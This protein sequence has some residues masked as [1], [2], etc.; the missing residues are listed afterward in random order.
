M[1]F[2]YNEV[3]TKVLLNFFLDSKVRTKVLV[4]FLEITGG[5]QKCTRI[6]PATVCKCD[7]ARNYNGLNAIAS[8]YVHLSNE[9]QWFELPPKVCKCDLARNY[10]G[11]SAIASIYVHLSQEIQWFELP[12]KVCKCDLARN[13]NGLSAI[14]VFPG[15]S[16]NRSKRLRACRRPKVP[17][18]D[19]Y[20]TENHH[21]FVACPKQRISA[22]QIGGI[23]DLSE[24]RSHRSRLA[25][26]RKCFEIIIPKK[27]IIIDLEPAWTREFRLLRPVG[28]W[29]CLILLI[30][31]L[32]K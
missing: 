23:L 12:P 27:E 4:G 8:I 28:F 31:T 18:N 9:L 6:L 10:N 30:A 13:Y 29:T 15:A 22:P 2:P 16:E 5:P 25:G 19:H 14:W 24:I 20:E 21:W 32:T 7:L 17:W 3:R 11:L 1:F 26:G